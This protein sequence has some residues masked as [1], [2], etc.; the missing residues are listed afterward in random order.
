MGLRKQFKDLKVG[1]RGSYLFEQ[2]FNEFQTKNLTTLPLE[3]VI[4]W[5]KTENLE[6]FPTRYN[7]EWM[8]IQETAFGFDAI[9]NH[10]GI[11]YIVRCS[12]I[13]NWE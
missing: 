9:Y 8:I 6:P 2:G 11:F 3:A 7:K 4:A 10:D 13:P 12:K 5:F 1:V